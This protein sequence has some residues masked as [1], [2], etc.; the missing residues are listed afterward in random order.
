MLINEPIRIRKLRLPVTLKVLCMSSQTIPPG[1]GVPGNT[2]GWNPPPAQWN[3]DVEEF[4]AKSLGSER[5]AAISNAVVR[6]PLLTSIRVNTLTTTVDDVLQ[7]LPSALTRN[8]REILLKRELQGD[9]EDEKSGRLSRCGTDDGKSIVS[10]AE[11]TSQSEPTAQEM[12]IYVH[13]E[14]PNAVIVP[15]SG[16]YVID[17]GKTEGREVIVGRKAGESM[18]RGSNAYAPGILACTAG[19]AEGDVVAV[20]IGIEIDE[21]SKSSSGNKFGCS[22]GTV[23]PQGLP[24][25]DPR[26]PNRS[27]LFIGVGKAEVPRSGFNPSGQGLV[28]T[29]TDRVFRT[30]ALGDILKGKLVLQNLPSLVTAWVADPRQGQRVLDMCAAP[31]NKTTALASLMND[32][33]EIIAIDRSHAK[34]QGIKSLCEELSV[35]CVKAFRADSTRL[36]TNPCGRRPRSDSNPSFS[37]SDREKQLELSKKARQKIEERKATLR[38]KLGHK[39]EKPVEESTNLNG[40]L[41]KESFD[42]VL[43]DAPCSALGLRPRLIVPH[44]MK[45]LRSTSSYQRRLIDEAVKLVK[46]GGSL[47]Y[48]TW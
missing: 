1:N 2:R 13:P 29:M 20:S 43:L 27:N 37:T 16:P 41:E 45:E 36:S 40:P 34:V 47:V 18:L 33:G 35:T 46:P 17:Y 6:P 30:P 31:G 11:L 48:S 4:L 28:L 8:D 5:L 42:V 12:G 26:F 21:D 10:T 25:D 7:R 32:E 19:I 23:I 14:V 22:R 15:G 9:L 3:A 39:P 24:L 44:T 38:A